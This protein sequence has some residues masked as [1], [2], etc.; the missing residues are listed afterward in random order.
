MKIIALL[1]PVIQWWERF[2]QA[3]P[4]IGFMAFVYGAVLVIVWMFS[5]LRPTRPWLDAVIIVIVH[6][7]QP[8]PLPPVIG[9]QREPFEDDDSDSFAE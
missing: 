2:S 1:E 8:S 7:S 6:K 3:N 9:R 5:R 4:G